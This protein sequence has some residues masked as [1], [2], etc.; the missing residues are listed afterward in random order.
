MQS[1][2]AQPSQ[3]Y[4]HKMIKA[5]TKNVNDF[6][7]IYRFKFFGIKVMKKKKKRPKENVVVLNQ[8][9]HFQSEILMKTTTTKEECHKYFGIVFLIS[10]FDVI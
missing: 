5:R 4:A 9:E 1:S 6:P 2:A 8:I 7:K 10:R 3:S